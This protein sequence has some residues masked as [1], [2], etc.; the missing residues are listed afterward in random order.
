M[1]LDQT[2]KGICPAVFR[3]QLLSPFHLAVL[4]E[5]DGDLVSGVQPISVCPDLANRQLAFVEGFDME[6]PVDLAHAVGKLI[7]KLNRDAQFNLQLR[8][9]AGAERAERRIFL[10]AAEFVS[11]R[12]KDQRFAV[13]DLHGK[14][15]EEL[16]HRCEGL[17]SATFSL[18]GFSS[19]CGTARM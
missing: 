8:G 9:L 16:R 15:L 12:V 2:V 6:D 17:F 5:V 1:P 11:F 10:K 4:E 3:V 14:L 7:V 13:P 19:P 18:S